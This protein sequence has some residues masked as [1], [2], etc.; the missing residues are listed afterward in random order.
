MDGLHLCLST[1]FIHARGTTRPPL[2]MDDIPEAGQMR[3]PRIPSVARGATIS[4]E[5]CTD[6]EEGRLRPPVQTS[7]KLSGELWRSLFQAAMQDQG[8]AQRGDAEPCGG[9]RRT[10]LCAPGTSAF[11]CASA[12]ILFK[13]GDVLLVRG[14]RRLRFSPQPWADSHLDWLCQGSLNSVMNQNLRP[15]HLL[16]YVMHYP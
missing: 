13:D 2:S 15:R 4:G 7:H 16:E 10:D 12:K 1:N 5:S 8:K 14:P 11:L 3:F 6:L 9:S